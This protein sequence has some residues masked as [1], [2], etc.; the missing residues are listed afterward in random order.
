MFTT[1]VIIVPELVQVLL[2]F[3]K[4]LLTTSRKDEHQSPED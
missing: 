2:A 1:A 3:Y 4:F